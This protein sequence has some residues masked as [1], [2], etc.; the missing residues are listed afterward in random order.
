MWA[1]GTARVFLDSSAA[2]LPRIRA[3]SAERRLLFRFALGVGSLALLLTRNRGSGELRGSIRGAFG[4]AAA[5]SVASQAPEGFKLRFGRFGR[6]RALQ[7][8]AF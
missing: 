7:S 6:V 4:G 5:H 3:R 2:G 1:E 8:A